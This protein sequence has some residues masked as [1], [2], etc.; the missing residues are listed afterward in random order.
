[1]LHFEL[2]KLQMVI[3]RENNKT[4]IYSRIN[5]LYKFYDEFDQVGMKIDYDFMLHTQFSDTCYKLEKQM[6]DI[7]KKYWCEYKIKGNLNNKNNIRM[8]KENLTIA[9][10]YGAQLCG[11]FITDKIFTKLTQLKINNFWKTKNLIPNDWYGL[12]K[13][14][15]CQIFNNNIYKPV[16]ESDLC[17]KITIEGTNIDNFIPDL[18]EKDSCEYQLNIF[19]NEIIYPESNYELITPENLFKNK[20]ENILIFNKKY[21]NK[22]FKKV[23]FADEE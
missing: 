11:Q 13:Y 9:M 5:E 1:M 3:F 12:T 17:Y 6:D 4:K 14:Y 20:Y 18:T 10:E 15:Y 7:E 22:K 19:D 2:E 16:N 21:F 23:R 8:D